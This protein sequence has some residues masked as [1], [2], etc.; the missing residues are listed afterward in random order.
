MSEKE[1]DPDK[2]KEIISVNKLEIIENQ[3]EQKKIMEIQVGRD[4][5]KIEYQV[6]DIRSDEEIKEAK[7]KNDKTIVVIPGFPSPI[8]TQREL[9]K[10][11]ALKGKRVITFSL[12]GLGNSDNPPENWLKGHLFDKQ[13]EV[14]N[15]LLENIIKQEQEQNTEI[16]TKNFDVVGI[17]MGT[18]IGAKL[19]KHHSKK[20]ANLVLITPVG[21]REKSTVE[22]AA[23]SPYSSLEEQRG[24]IEEKF[25]DN[26]EKTKRAFE[27]MKKAGEVGISEWT[28]SRKKSQRLTEIKLMAKGGL[29]D[30]LKN[31]EGNVLAMTGSRDRI[32]R[33]DQLD[34]IKKQCDK[35]QVISK[36][37]PGASHG[38]PIYDAEEY[39]E[40]TIKQLNKWHEDE[41]L[42]K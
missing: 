2:Y 8:D 7:E 37:I 3:L 21:V 17:S 14:I 40:E 41:L 4:K 29:T 13:S 1:F 20:V 18:M 31:H 12:P 22:L 42:K 9:N 19:T 33:P 26:P 23:R 28:G 36:I 6:L 16:T 39:A 30:D 34:S 24:V 25:K 38:G 5:L 27:R 35:A 10:S 15:Q 11:L 32:S